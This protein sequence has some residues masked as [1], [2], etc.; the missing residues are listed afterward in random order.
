MGYT[1]YWNQKRAFTDEEWSEIKD[2]FNYISMLSS[3]I[4]LDVSEFSD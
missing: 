3:Q 1:N 4:K 2:Y